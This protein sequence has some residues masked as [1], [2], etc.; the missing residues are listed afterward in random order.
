MAG[1]TPLEIRITVNRDGNARFW[2]KWEITAFAISDKGPSLLDRRRMFGGLFFER[3]LK[4]K[5]KRIQHMQGHVQDVL[6]SF[7]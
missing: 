7:N 6:A 5:I 4:R 2:R 3:R 1:T